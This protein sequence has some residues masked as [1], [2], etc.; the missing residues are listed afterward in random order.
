VQLRVTGLVSPAELDAVQCSINVVIGWKISSVML[1]SVRVGFTP[2]QLLFGHP[3]VAASTVAAAANVAAALLEVGAGRVQRAL[4][5]YDQQRRRGESNTESSHVYVLGVSFP[6]RTSTRRIEGLDESGSYHH[7]APTATVERCPEASP[8]TL[9]G[10]PSPPF[11]DHARR[12]G[13]A[14]GPAKHTSQ[15]ERLR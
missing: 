1:V 4:E 11:V 6:R 5:G 8:Q 2:V 15:Q 7:E 14:I 3:A 12:L 9:G 10:C 13:V